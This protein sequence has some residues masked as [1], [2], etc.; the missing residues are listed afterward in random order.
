MPRNPAIIGVVN[1][2]A[3]DGSVSD[4]PV[5]GADVASTK[6]EA[7]GG[8][9]GVGADPAAV[10]APV[11][12]AGAAAMAKAIRP[13]IGCPSGPT[14]RQRNVTSPGGNAGSVAET[15]VFPPGP[16]V[17]SEISERVPVA[18]IISSEAVS[19]GTAAANVIKSSAGARSSKNRPPAHS[20]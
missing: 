4:V 11:V 2:S 20:T 10:A 9:A 18:S 19:S 8:A 1:G 16:M 12:V 14:R 13:V 6:V 3:K 7:V 15:S 17:T 5:S